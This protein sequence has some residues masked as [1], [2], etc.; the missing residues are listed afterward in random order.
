MA[1]GMPKQGGVIRLL[2]DADAGSWLMV[3]E[4]IETCLT[5]QGRIGARPVW[6]CI[7]AGNMARLPY[8]PGIE[9]LI[10]LTDW[11]R[12]NRRTGKRAGEE[13]AADLAQA[14][15]P[16]CPFIAAINAEQEG[17]DLND[18]FASMERGAAA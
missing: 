4:G 12:A 11:D 5:V 6:A 10:V 2:D 18:L 1:K 16:H 15:E 8:V 13:A 9:T 7:D 14:W 3:G 17:W